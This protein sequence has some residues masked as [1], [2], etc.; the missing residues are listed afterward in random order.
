MGTTKLSI[1]VSFPKKCFFFVYLMDETIFMKRT[2]DDDDDND[3]E[4]TI[5][6]IVVEVIN[7]AD[8]YVIVMYNLCWKSNKKV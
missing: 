8:V 6:R 3:D 4:R 5:V 2:Y 7:N 1:F